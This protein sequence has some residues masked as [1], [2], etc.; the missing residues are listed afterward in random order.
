MTETSIDG[1]ETS[2]S[3]LGT[4][5]LAVG[6]GL[7]A[8][9][10]VADFWSAVSRFILRHTFAVLGVTLLV[11]CGV[12][13]LWRATDSTD[14]S[15]GL[16]WLERESKATMAGGNSPR[17][18]ALEW[19]GSQLDFYS[20]EVSLYFRLYFA[21]KVLALLAASALPI[22]AIALHDDKLKLVTASLGAVVVIAEGMIQ[23]FKLR[24]TWISAASTRQAIEH[25][26]VLFGTGAG[27][28]RAC[29]DAAPPRFVSR[30][31]AII[32]SEYKDWAGRLRGDISGP[33][34]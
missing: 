28:Y 30:V 32:D 27:P 3:R 14:A 8:A 10:V 11:A 12:A 23:L 26:I 34:Q 6:L 24:E 4:W 16:E 5:A 13:A 17:A 20:N 25:E 1:R 33:L 7:G 31:A 29:G 19:V 18:V 2:G 22:C 9:L 21:C 15:D